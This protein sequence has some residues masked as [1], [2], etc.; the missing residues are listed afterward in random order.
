MGGGSWELKTKCQGKKLIL[1]DSEDNPI[2]IFEYPVDMEPLE[3][4]ILGL[5]SSKLV[6]LC[7]L[8]DLLKETYPDLTWEP[9]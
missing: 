7:Q 5:V 8:K 6:E 3:D 1:Y 4:F 2:S 9:E